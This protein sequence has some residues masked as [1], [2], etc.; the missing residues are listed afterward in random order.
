MAMNVCC[1]ATSEPFWLEVFS[2][3]LFDDAPDSFEEAKDDVSVGDLYPLGR[4]LMPFV[5]L[6]LDGGWQWGHR[7]PPFAPVC[8]ERIIA[9]GTVGFFEH[10]LV[11]FGAP[12]EK[13]A[14][15]EEHDTDPAVV[16]LVDDKR[17][18]PG[19]ADRRND[20]MGGFDADDV[21]CADH[22]TQYA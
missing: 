10:H 21:D 12:F 19:V 13:R 1:G 22:K 6:V 20:E 7:S 8:H 3:L 5:A 4:F 14:E 2:G 18:H 9:Y 16:V 15:T 17:L 11:V